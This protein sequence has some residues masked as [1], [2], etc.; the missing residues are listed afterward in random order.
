MDG[1]QVRLLTLGE[2]QVWIDDNIADEIEMLNAKGYT[3]ASCC[4]GHPLNGEMV[5]T[6]SFYED[7]DFILPKKF[8]AKRK[9]GNLGIYV[10]YP[11]GDKLR[12]KHYYQSLNDFKQ[13]VKDLPNNA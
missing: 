3:T 6:I 10:H 9:H 2:N 1:R 7:Y 12:E 13:W 11:F 5:I 4:G 8:K